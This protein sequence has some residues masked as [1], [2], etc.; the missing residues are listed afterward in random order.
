MSELIGRTIREVR[1]MTAAEQSGEGW[2]DASPWER[3]VVLVLD[4]GTRLYPARDPEGNGP[5]ALFGVDPRGRAFTLHP[6][7]RE[8]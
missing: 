3:P 2:E 1:P 4:D 6:G 7:P 5:G 8:P